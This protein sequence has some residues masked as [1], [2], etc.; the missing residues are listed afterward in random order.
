MIGNLV[1]NAAKFKAPG[2][3]VHITIE[4]ERRAERMRIWVED[5]GIGIAPEHQARIFNVFERLHGQEIYPGT[6]VGLAIVKMGVERMGG[7][8]GVESA[9]DAGSRFWIE[10][11]AAEDGALDAPS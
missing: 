2:R 6:G 4:A 5:D 11:A 3:G 7:T 1:V 8:C 10:L 9:L